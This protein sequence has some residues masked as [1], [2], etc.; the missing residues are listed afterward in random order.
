MATG[1]WIGTGV[2]FFIVLNAFIKDT[3]AKK[4][5]IQAWT[6]ISTA[7]LLWPITLPFILSSKLRMAKVRQ[8]A[9]TVGSDVDAD[10]E[11]IFTAY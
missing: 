1:Y 2:T 10:T 3:T 6:F 5:S 9:N 8:Q 7:A 11:V 4:T